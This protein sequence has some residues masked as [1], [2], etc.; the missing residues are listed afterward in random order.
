MGV[1]PR[2]SFLRCHGRTCLPTYARGDFAGKRFD[3]AARVHFV[4]PLGGCC[5]WRG[6]GMVK[7]LHCVRGIGFIREQLYQNSHLSGTR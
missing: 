3:I 2:G 5:C 7:R 1:N 6:D 4:T